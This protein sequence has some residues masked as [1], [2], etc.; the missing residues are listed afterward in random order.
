MYRIVGKENLAAVNEVAQR[1]MVIIHNLS[2]VED[3]P[4]DTVKVDKDI[5]L[6]LA[7]GYLY[8]YEVVLEQGLLPSSKSAKHGIFKLH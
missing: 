3:D 2:K 5:L 6:S 1:S 4:S 7:N 8:L